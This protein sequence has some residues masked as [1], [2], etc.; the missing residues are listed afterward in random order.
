MIR[1]EKSDALAFEI[2]GMKKNLSAMTNENEQAYFSNETLEKKAEDMQALNAR[3]QVRLAGACCNAHAYTAAV[4][5]G[6]HV[7]GVYTV[8]YASVLSLFRKLWGF[9]LIFSVHLHVKSD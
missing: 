1:Q 4:M 8:L 5:F 2:E 9:C 3:L 7:V 6:Y